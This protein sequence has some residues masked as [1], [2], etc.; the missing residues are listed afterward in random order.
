MPSAVTISIDRRL[1]H[2]NPYARISRPIPPPSVNPPMPV[3]ET[4]PGAGRGVQRAAGEGRRLAHPPGVARLRRR[5]IDNAAGRPEPAE[6]H[7]LRAISLAR[8]GATFID[9]VAPSPAR[10]PRN[11]PDR[12]GPPPAGSRLDAGPR[13]PGG[14]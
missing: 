4:S 13:P 3:V 12:A 2:A 11:P 9:G 14:R 1:S 5:E 6:R 10:S 7:Y 8:A